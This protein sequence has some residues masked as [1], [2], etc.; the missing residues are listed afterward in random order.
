LTDLLGSRAADMVETYAGTG[1]PFLIS[2]HFSAPHWPWEAPGD[3]AESQRLRN[4]FHYDGGTQR[5]YP[6]LADWGRL[7]SLSD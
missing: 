2:L 7:H 5:T 3:E 4:L 6:I 1:Q